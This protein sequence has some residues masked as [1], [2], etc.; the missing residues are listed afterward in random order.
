[1]HGYFVDVRLYRK[2][3]AI[4]DPFAYE[5]YKKRNIIEHIEE[6][7][8]SRVQLKVSHFCLTIHICICLS[9]VS[10]YFPKFPIYYLLPH[11]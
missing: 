9:A 3:L 6:E 7:R 8:K 5:R 4:A 11:F 10:S 2:A 1:M